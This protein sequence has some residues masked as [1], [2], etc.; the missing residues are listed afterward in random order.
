[1]VLLV[2][3]CSG[4]AAW[5]KFFAVISRRCSKQVPQHVERV[6]EALIGAD[7]DEDMVDE[8]GRLRNRVGVALRLAK[9]VKLRFGG[10]PQLTEANRLVAARYIQDA[11]TDAGI[12]RKVDQNRLLYRVRAL[13]FTRL[14]EER[15]EEQLLNSATLMR[16]HNAGTGWYNIARS[17]WWLPAW[18]SNGQVWRTVRS[19]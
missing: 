8:E 7:D 16:E 2:L 19:A 13:V 10:T 4:I 17:V 1:M 14:A 5:G 12:T 11:M 18:L 3:L 6:A 9:E 15:E